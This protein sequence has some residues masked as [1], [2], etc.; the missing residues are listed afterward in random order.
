MSNFNFS[1]YVSS[2]A[3]GYGIK[4]LYDFRKR[5]FDVILKCSKFRVKMFP[6][7]CFISHGG[8]YRACELFSNVVTCLMMNK[9]GGIYRACELFSNVVTRLMMNKNQ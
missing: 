8:I 5:H 1:S 6:C 7:F 2:Q 3:S 4:C 9:S